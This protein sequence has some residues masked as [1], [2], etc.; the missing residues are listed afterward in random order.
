MTPFSRNRD[1]GVIQNEHRFY[2]S[3][4]KGMRILSHDHLPHQWEYYHMT[5]YPINENIIT[6]PPTP[7]MRILSH[8]HLPHLV[9]SA[10]GFPEVSD[11]RQL[12]VDGAAVEPAVVQVVHRLLSVFLIAELFTKQSL[13]FKENCKKKRAPELTGCLWNKMLFPMHL[14]PSWHFP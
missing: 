2:P 7:S 4:N 1:N 3:E 12:W 5:T 13:T 8:D 9:L 10:A 6:W 11:R 14:K